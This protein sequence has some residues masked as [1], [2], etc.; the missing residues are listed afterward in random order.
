MSDNHGLDDN[1][2]TATTLGPAFESEAVVVVLSTNENFVPYVSCVLESILDNSS[3]DRNYDI[4]VLHR[5]VTD[6]SKKI[7]EGQAKQKNVSIRL[8]DLTSAIDR[9]GNLYVH[10]HFKVETY[11]RLIIPEI[12]PWCHKALYLDADIIVLRDV[13]ELFDTDVEGYM[14]AATHDADTAGQYNGFDPGAKHYMDDILKIKSPYDYFQA[15]I[16]LFNLDEISARYTSE[17]MLTYASSY[18]W[19]LLDQDVLN[20][21]AQGHVRYVDMAWNTLMDWQG[22]R[23]KYIIGLAPENLRDAYEK[24]RLDPFIV[25]YAGP[26][27][28]P[29]ECKKVDFG[30]YFWKYAALSPFAE[31]FHDRYKMMEHSFAH[32]VQLITDFWSYRVILPIGAVVSPPGSLLRKV[33]YRVYRFF[34]RLD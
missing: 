33:F 29:W 13:A 19:T 24:A 15:G 8:F 7:L 2:A 32:T 34:I 5:S 9:F 4:I 6:K 21:L 14:I 30:E 31:D 18:H 11:F 3:L 22:L 17:E 12:M 28:K 10:G 26:G 20:F 16:I 27:N 23:R 25:H 1:F